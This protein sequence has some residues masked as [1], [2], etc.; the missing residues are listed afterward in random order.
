MR[1]VPSGAS[2]QTWQWETAFQ[3]GIKNAKICKVIYAFGNL[4]LGLKALGT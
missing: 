1:E 4:H 2:S 3:I